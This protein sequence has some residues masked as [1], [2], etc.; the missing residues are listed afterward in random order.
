MSRTVLS[1]NSGAL[2]KSDV[3]VFLWRSYGAAIRSHKRIRCA[4]INKDLNTYR[5]TALRNYQIGWTD[6]E[7]VES[8]VREGLDRELRNLTLK[9]SSVFFE[10]LEEVM[11][12]YK[13]SLPTSPAKL[14]DRFSSLLFRSPQGKQFVASWDMK[15]FLLAV[16]L[17]MTQQ[18]MGLE[19]QQAIN[20]LFSEHLRPLLNA[21]DV[22]VI[23]RGIHSFPTQTDQCKL[24]TVRA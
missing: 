4:L 24:W 9:M 2:A 8:L 13:Q 7:S 19:D 12:D 15:T 18:G 10:V 11:Q 3:P 1:Q 21:T 22:Y 5:E 6:P 23:L 14:I 20:R 16:E 17:L